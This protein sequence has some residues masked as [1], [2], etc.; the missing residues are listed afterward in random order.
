[1]ARYLALHLVERED[2]PGPAGGPP[3]DVWVDLRVNPQ[4]SHVNIVPGD[5]LE[6]VSRDVAPQITGTLMFVV[7]RR[8]GA[9]AGSPLRL[10]SRWLGQPLACRKPVPPG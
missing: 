6:F 10:G 3:P 8:Y 1:M 2:L 4:G 7:I 9:P 5:I